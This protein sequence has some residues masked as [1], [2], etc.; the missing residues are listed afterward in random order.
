M[1]RN[2]RRSGASKSLLGVKGHW[3]VD[4]REAAKMG[5]IHAYVPAPHI[6]HMI[7]SDTIPAEF[8]SAVAFPKCA[9]VINDIRDRAT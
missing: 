7:D 6:Q 3:G 9:K 2:A 8:D 1:I 4:I 5:E